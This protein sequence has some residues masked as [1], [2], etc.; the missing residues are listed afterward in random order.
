MV[1]VLFVVGCG[2]L[3]LGRSCGS[4]AIFL[5]PPLFIESNVL[6]A[7]KFTNMESDPAFLNNDA[8]LLSPVKMFFVAVSL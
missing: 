2:F 7:W 4:D 5:L 1:W 6:L 8:R 3:R